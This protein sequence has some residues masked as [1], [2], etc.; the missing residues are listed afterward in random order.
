MTSY[1]L[2]ALQQQFYIQ[3]HIQPERWLH[4]RHSTVRL[5]LYKYNGNINN[6]ENKYPNAGGLTELFRIKEGELLRHTLHLWGRPH[7][8]PETLYD[9][10][11]NGLAT[12]EKHNDFFEAEHYSGDRQNAAPFNADGIPG[13]HQV[14]CENEPLQSSLSCHK[15]IKFISGVQTVRDWFILRWDSGSPAP[16][17]PART[18]RGSLSA[19]TGERPWQRYTRR[20]NKPGET[21][22]RRRGQPRGAGSSLRGE[23]STQRLKRNVMTSA[24][25]TDAYSPLLVNITPPPPLPTHRQ[26]QWK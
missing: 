22:R 25:T 14:V 24:L 5:L 6:T 7:E 23:I 8:D 21:G 17:L 18:N 2:C 10:K 3:V 9:W 26:T 19:V 11:T 16:C 12:C 20:S 1:G 4:V 13:I 15:I